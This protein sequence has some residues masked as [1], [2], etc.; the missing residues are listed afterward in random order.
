MNRKI[1]YLHL[2]LFVLAIIVVRPVHA[3]ESIFKNSEF[4]TWEQ[5]NQ[6]FYIR[7]SIGMAILIIAQYD[8]PK[9]RCMT[10][11][12]NA[13]ESG[14]YAFALDAMKRFPEYTPKGTV[15]AVIEKK[16]GKLEG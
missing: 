13:D 11:A 3:E 8:K 12:F 1:H 16:C 7:T 9:A 10:D 4:L 15:L 2:A 14:M 6:E 5:T